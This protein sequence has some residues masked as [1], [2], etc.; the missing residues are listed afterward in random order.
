MPQGAMTGCAWRS[1]STY[2]GHA[3]REDDGANEGHLGSALNLSP[4]VLQK[5]V[6]YFLQNMANNSVQTE[7]ESCASVSLKSAP[8]DAEWLMTVVRAVTA[9]SP[10]RNARCWTDAN[11]PSN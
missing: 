3:R 6:K 5:R 10:P 4:C 1:R 8:A 2:C 9:Y 7:H 11:N